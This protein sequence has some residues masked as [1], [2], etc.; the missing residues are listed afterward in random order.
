MNS[1]QLIPLNALNKATVGAL[2]LAILPLPY[3]YYIFLR[4]AV[5][6]SVCAHL[7]FGIQRKRWIGVAIFAAIGALFNPFE[8]IYLTKGIWIFIDFFAALFVK[9]GGEELIKTQAEQSTE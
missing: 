5:M 6:L 4:W 7:Y 9:I 8:P 2:L 1:D 3:S